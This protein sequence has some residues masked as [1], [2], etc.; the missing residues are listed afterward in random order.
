MQVSPAAAWKGEVNNLARSPVVHP[1]GGGRRKK[2]LAPRWMSKAV[3]G[4]NPSAWAKALGRRASRTPETA[5]R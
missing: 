2:H 3:R 1:R 4:S 5:A